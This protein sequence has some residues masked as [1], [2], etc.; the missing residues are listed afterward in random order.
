MRTSKKLKKD[1]ER[2]K[3][4]I[5][6]DNYEAALKI[7]NSL[8]NPWDA[9]QFIRLILRI[10]KKPRL[11]LNEALSVFVNL[12][13]EEIFGNHFGWVHSLSHFDDVLWKRRITKWIKILYEIALLGSKDAQRGIYPC[14]RLV[15]NFDS[16]SK[17]F[18]DPNI[19]YL[20]LDNT[21]WFK[22][23]N[24]N[25]HIKERI[26]NSPFKSEKDYLLWR[27]ENPSSLLIFDFYCQDM[28]YSLGEIRKCIHRMYEL[29]GDFYTL[30]TLEKK[31][32]KNQL[33]SYRR[34][35]KK[36]KN[37]SER[38]NALKAVNK[39]EWAL[40]SRYLTIP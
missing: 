38:E 13:N 15:Y 18:D 35:Y 34:K 23:Q 5:L 37:E 3:R 11:L 28:L 6:E 12:H 30:M 39:L 21:K 31:L 29:S 26:K 4:L 27:F 20:T 24:Y 25:K 1:T 14:Y 2:L 8:D 10:P 33:R 22:D 9:E 17:W 36:A 16:H 19:Y 40:G 32:L 7:I